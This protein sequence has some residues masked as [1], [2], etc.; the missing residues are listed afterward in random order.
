MLGKGFSYES[1]FEEVLRSPLYNVIGGYTLEMAR[2][3][4]FAVLFALALTTVSGCVQGYDGSPRS[5]SE[6]HER[7]EKELRQRRLPEGD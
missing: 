3:V 5:A 2:T 7:I 1:I 6:W 4:L